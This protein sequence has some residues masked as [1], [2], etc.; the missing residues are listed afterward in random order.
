M[1][2][3]QILYCDGREVCVG[4]RVLVDSNRGALVTEVLA[5]GAEASAGD[6]LANGGFLL[7][8]DDG[9]CQLWQI[10]DEDVELISR[11]V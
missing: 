6:K 2:D 4:D 9:D 5:A 3:N 7:Q 1:S 11:G 10:A 8:F